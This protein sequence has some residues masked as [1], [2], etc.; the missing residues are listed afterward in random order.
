[1]LSIQKLYTEQISEWGSVWGIPDLPKIVTINFSNRLKK[2]LGRVRPVS[3]VV[4]LNAKLSSLH[5]SVILE[6]LCHEIAHV[7]A[8]ILHG[9]HAKPHGPEWRALVLAAGYKPSTTMKA[10]WL[11]D[12]G[13]VDA[14]LG[15]KKHY[16]C[17]V[18]QADYFVRRRSSHLY[19]ESCLQN[20]VTV[21]LQFISHDTI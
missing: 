3:G 6:V 2:S 9:S 20:G 21:R 4:T 1:V 8:Y 16:R 12:P 13:K 18:C 5:S 17:S 11:P 14:H 19:C 15:M 7:V 10:R